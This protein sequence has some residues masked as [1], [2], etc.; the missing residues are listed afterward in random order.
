MVDWRFADGSVMMAVDVHPEFGYRID[1]P[2]AGRFRVAAD[3][4]M[5]EC[6]PAPGPSWWWHRPFLAQV[7]PLVAVLNDMELL[8][9]SG[10]V[11]GGG[12]FAFVGHSGAGKTSLATHLVDQG[13]KLLTDDV[14]SLSCLGE[15]LQ[16]HPGVRFS[17]LAQ[18]QLDAI[19]PERRERIGRVVGRSEK[20]HVLFDQMAET[21]APLNALYFLNRRKEVRRLEFEPLSPPDPRLLLGSSCISY[22]RTTARISRRLEICSLLANQVPIFRLHVPPHLSA[23]ELA[24]LVAVH[25]GRVGTQGT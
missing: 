7:L 22:V 20:L 2:G 10:V 21:D 12:G 6:A 8:H 16:V 17:N 9:A 14:V 5:V 13:A 23:A 1:T 4:S 24:P 3:G 19:A 18:E 11:I 25:G 15:S